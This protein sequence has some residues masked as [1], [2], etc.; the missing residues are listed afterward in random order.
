MG[1]EASFG[2]IDDMSPKNEGKKIGTSP[3]NAYIA[4]LEAFL[5]PLCRDLP[6]RPHT[7]QGEG[8]YNE[9]VA[10]ANAAY[11]CLDKTN[12]SPAGQTQ[13]EPCDLYSIVD[14][15]GVFYHIK[16]STLSAQLSHLFNQGTNAMELLK[17]EEEA[18]EKLKALINQ[19]AVKGT[20]E[21]FFQPIDERKY[22][23]VF[24]IVTHKDK[25]RKSKNLPL[26]SRV[27]LRRN[28]KAL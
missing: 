15:L 18:V 27:S 25:A 6:L 16:I 4:K 9:A 13:I 8:A 2:F 10:A 24:G 28:M 11:I 23:V 3:E 21:E 5:D 20:A 14:N 22:K 1:V 12:I 17:L 19:K 26:F 7:L